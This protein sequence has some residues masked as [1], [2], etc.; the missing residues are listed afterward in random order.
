MKNTDRSQADRAQKDTNGPIVAFEE[1]DNGFLLISA[2]SDI[3]PGCGLEQEH[4]DIVADGASDLMD[5]KI[6]CLPS[7][8]EDGNRQ[9]DRLLSGEF[10]ALNDDFKSESTDS[11]DNS[12][13]NECVQM[14]KMIDE[15]L[16]ASEI[17]EVR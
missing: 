6:E 8:T 12:L 5:E 9:Q 3:G 15:L 1:E 16:T 13:S 14:I 7:R 10:S 4:Q 17:L 11:E 2:A